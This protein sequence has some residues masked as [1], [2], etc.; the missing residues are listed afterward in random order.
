MNNNNSNNNNNEEEEKRRRRNALIIRLRTLRRESVPG[1]VLSHQ[2]LPVQ[3]TCRGELPVHQYYYLPKPLRRTAKNVIPWFT[4]DHRRIF[5]YGSSVCV[6]CPQGPQTSKSTCLSWERA[7]EGGSVR[8][9][10]YVN[11]EGCR[12]CTRCAARFPNFILGQHEWEFE[13]TDVIDYG[14]IV[15]DVADLAARRTLLK[16]RH[17]A[18]KER[19]KEVRQ[20]VRK[21]NRAILSNG[22][23]YIVMFNGGV[24]FGR[25]IGKAKIN[26]IVHVKREN[27]TSMIYYVETFVALMENSSTPAVRAMFPNGVLF[28]WVPK[29]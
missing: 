1:L 3:N 22:R 12:I 26:G 18:R 28:K 11:K 20:C 29:V 19:V 17:V 16:Q 27:G 5:G 8:A 7:G 10:T 24:E 6:G 9:Q 2:D 14:R 23:N 25:I 4:E 21:V 13:K 15:D